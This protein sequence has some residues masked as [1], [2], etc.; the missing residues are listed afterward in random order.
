MK[1]II[2]ASLIAIIIHLV[3][4]FQINE[5]IKNNQ[6][7]YNTTNKVKKTKKHG[8]T[9]IKYV[10]LQQRKIIKPTIKKE[11]QKPKKVK[12][13]VLKEVE[14]KKTVKKN[15]PIKKLKEI[16][17]NKKIQ[18]IQLPKKTKKVDLKQF[19]TLSKKEQIK[20]E[21]NKKKI[22]EVRETI[23]QLQNLDRL[24]Q[25][26]IKLYGEEFF[27]YSKQQQRFLKTNLSKIGQITQRYLQ[28]PEI[29]VRTRQSGTNV[30]EF[31]LHK[32][33][34]IT[35]LRITDSS[36]YTALDK[37]TLQTIKIA[38]KDYPKPFQ[39]TKIKIYVKY[40]LY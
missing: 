32:N 19:F 39:V 27:T 12:R 6:L 10:K 7:K 30:I 15:K 24:T 11:I 8:Y 34:D 21:S 28:Y 29:S 17:V 23:K 4:F 26:Y 5:I 25:S 37:N 22:E 38:Y 9:N 31:L 14:Q 13:T 16:V 40:I 18:P 35:N 3:L 2:Y 33:G 1:N 36:Q 20:K